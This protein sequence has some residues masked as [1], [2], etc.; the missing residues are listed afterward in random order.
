MMKKFLKIIVVSLLVLV[1]S[2]CSSRFDNLDVTHDSQT[3]AA[4]GSLDIPV[5]KVTENANFFPV[6]V[7]GTRMEV[8]AVKVDG[9]V[10]TAFNT[11]QICNGQ[12]RAYFV[13]DRRMI[14]CLACGNKYQLDIVEV[15]SGGCSPIPIKG[16]S[17]TVTA[18][19]V[20]ISYETLQAGIQY[21]P[22]NWKTD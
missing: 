19:A 2:A 3:I 7:D 20:S 5:D 16:D 8:L 22:A 11:C 10:R 13:Q 4:G 17:K 21:F 9:E 15:D 18:D 14:Q 1:L 12:P 6:V